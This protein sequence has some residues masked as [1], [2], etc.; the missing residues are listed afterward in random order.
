M[1]EQVW[2]CQVSRKAKGPFQTSIE[3]LTVG[4]KFYLQCHT[5]NEKTHAESNQQSVLTENKNLQQPMAIFLKQHPW[6]QYVLKPLKNL[7]VSDEHIL[8]ETTS[9]ISGRY[10]AHQGLFL[11]KGDH[12]IT[13]EGISWHTKSSFSENSQQQMEMAQ[14]QPH[15]IYGLIKIPSSY[16]EIA[17]WIGSLLAVLITGILVVRKIKRQKDEFND[18]ENL[19]TLRSPLYEFYHQ[20]KKIEKKYMDIPTKLN[21][22]EESKPP[23]K[24]FQSNLHFF[25]R[26][27]NRIF[28]KFLAVQLEFPAHIWSSRKSLKYLKKQYFD[29]ELLKYIKSILYELNQMASVRGP[30]LEEDCHQNLSF[31]KDIA[32]QIVNLQKRKDF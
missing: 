7:S 11:Q 18:I 3:N 10:N 25:Y 16:L 14:I 26:D 20:A 24:D 31:C 21:N 4:E 17:F 22:D 19:K 1:L 32:N 2:N 9:Y 27:L 29:P 12:I 28:Q 30:I 15:S 8:L 23:Q 5:A 6:P 13:L